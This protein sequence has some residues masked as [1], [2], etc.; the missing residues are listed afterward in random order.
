ML[1]SSRGR[2]Q[3]RSA[4]PVPFAVMEP[5]PRKKSNIVGKILMVAGLTAMCIIMLKQFPSFNTP[6]HVFYCILSLTSS[7][8]GYSMR[9]FTIILLYCIQNILQIS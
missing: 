3:T 1:N 9:I 5:D 6:T 2:S 4:R 7:Y 8:T